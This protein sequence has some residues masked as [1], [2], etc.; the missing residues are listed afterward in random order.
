MTAFDPRR[1]RRMQPIL[2]QALDLPAAERQAWLDEA[3][4]ADPELRADVEAVLRADAEASAAPDARTGAAVE[5][6]M[7][8]LGAENGRT[9]T[10]APDVQSPHDAGRF[11]PGAVIAGRYRI[12]SLLGRGGMGEVYRADDLKLG[13]AVALKFLPQRHERAPALLHRL[14]E[15]A[16]LARQ[17]AHPNV[18]RVYDVGEAEGR[19]FITM[20]YVDGEDLA[21]LLKRIGHLPADKALA[22][23]RQLCAGLAAA[24]DQGILHRDLKPA[25]V[26]L[27]GRGRVRI[28]DFGLAVTA[29]RI[30]GR[31]TP[32]TP[33]YMAPEQLAGHAAS[34]KSDVYALGLVL[35]EL[36]TGR[37]AF[38]GSSVEEL[39]RLKEERAPTSP[40]QLVDGVDPE[41]E[42]AILRCLE[43]D[44]ALRPASVRALATALPGGD[45]IAAALAAGD[46]PSPELVAASGPEGALTPRAALTTLG[47]TVAM[48]V[49][50]V[51][52]SDRATMLGWLREIRSPDVLEDNARVILKRLGY[53]T[54]A[55]DHAHLCHLWDLPYLAHV[56]AHDRS[57]DRW[58]ALRDLCPLIG[59]YF[60]RQSPRY[61]VPLGAQGRVTP[62]DPAP[63]PGEVAL[64]TDLRGRLVWLEVQPDEAEPPQ[65]TAPTPDWSRLFAEAGLDLARF[66]PVEPT[67]N[68]ALAGEVR[69]AWS[70]VLDDFGGYPVR[71]EAA[72][73]RGKPVFFELVVPWDRYW[74]PGNRSGPAPGP[75]TPFLYGV[76]LL[77]AL[78]VMGALA[79][80]HWLSGRGDRRGAFRVAATILVLRFGIWVLGGHHVPALEPESRLLII[81]LGKSLVDAAVS[82]CLY[83]A[84]EPPARRLYPRVL[85]SW[86]R[87]L[88]GRFRDP[89]VG[90]DI[91]YGVALSTFVILCWGQ[92]YVV[93]PHALG[94][95][96]PPPP[97]PYPM[98]SGPYRV[99]LDPPLPQPI[100]GG[101]YVLEGILARGLEAFGGL[102]W[103]MF[104]I[105]LRLLLRRTWAALLVFVAMMSLLPWPAQ[106]SGLSPVA[107]V[108]AFLGTLGIVAAYRVGLVAT[109]ALLGCLFLWMNFPIT[110]R[111]DAPHFGIGL[112]AVL[113]IAA[114]GAYGAFTAA[115]PRRLLNRVDA[116]WP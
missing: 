55:V 20:E 85:V 88:R 23:A 5:S 33:L 60:Y 32:G 101:R 87:L 77:F 28:T 102:S 64:Q 91:L 110:A 12:V 41:V 35:Y 46:T 76:F 66:Q 3:C 14:L 99:A 96:A 68:P 48:L 80:Q 78:A 113:S 98:G 43:A 19:E 116:P 10:G 7:R 86:T 53:D 15:E 74:Q 6:F 92:L 56:R 45:P 26:M 59:T 40:R 49:V 1:W 34:A 51:L 54:P 65:P 81:A 79:L 61:L 97:L 36:F 73:H 4:A 29:E 63:A 111:I 9:R 94:L 62:R 57:P 24:H 90:R 39:R 50:L 67:R 112:V 17:V 69:A 27:D 2:D 83:L 11:L 70:G 95:T 31:D 75:A 72:A 105:G 30:E 82:W 109:V 93:I 13:Q 104:L 103:G 114:L 44:P 84:L 22:I 21:S 18:C 89:L 106:L 108:F 25:N 115:R 38:D 107:I 8:R 58:K 52:L 42:R 47:A 71:V 100:L 37:R 16:K